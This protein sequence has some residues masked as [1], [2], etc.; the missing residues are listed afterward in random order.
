MAESLAFAIEISPYEGVRL[1]LRDSSWMDSSDFVPQRRWAHHLR[2][3]D[4]Y[5]LV[6]A[7]NILSTFALTAFLLSTVKI[8]SP[9]EES[10]VYYVL[11]FICASTI[12]FYTKALCKSVTLE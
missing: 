6:L 11:C 2:Q 10:L 5:L 4:Y 1:M 7:P 8:L 3:R 12:P 9:F